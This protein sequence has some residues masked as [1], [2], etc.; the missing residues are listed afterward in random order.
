MKAKYILGLG[1]AVMDYL[2]VVERFPNANT[3]VRS[4]IADLQGGGQ[5]P[6]RVRAA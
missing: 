5:D 1:A 4:S 2:Q 3:K 6:R